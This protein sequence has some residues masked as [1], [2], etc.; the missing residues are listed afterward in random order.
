MENKS[1][2]LLIIGAGPGGQAAALEAAGLGLRVVMAEGRELGGVCLN[3][4]CIPTKTLLHTAA[5]LKE[6]QEARTYGLSLKEAQ[7]DIP[8]LFQRKD[9]VLAQL[10]QGLAAQLKKAGVELM[11]G[12]ATVLG[13]GLARLIS[14]EQGQELTLRA[15]NILIATGSRPSLPPIPG[16][17]LPGV[18]DSDGILAA[19]QNYQSLTIIG[20]GVI[21]LEM[22]AVYA[23]LGCR[24]TVL[25]AL[26]RV[27]ANFDQEISQHMAVQLKK[28][29]IKTY[30]GARLSRVRQAP[31]G[32]ECCFEHKGKELA[33]SSQAVLVATGRC[34]NSR[35]LF[36]PELDFQLERG[37]I[38]VDG[39]FATALPGVYAIGDVAL[40]S[41]QLA[42]VAAAQGVNAVRL[43]QGLDPQYD[44]SVLPA[45]VYTSPEIASVG[46]TPD[47]ARQ[48]GLELLTGRASSLANGRN[49]IENGG[50][51]FCRLV[52]DKGSRV[53]VGVQLMCPRASDI[54]CGLADGVTAGL[55]LNQLAAT[56]RPHPSFG[57]LVGEAV[58]DALACALD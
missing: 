47:Q 35:G 15:K 55:T 32:L 30:T 21:G 40:G 8:A 24:V 43:M 14:A 25:E 3:R 17:D 22:A 52:F 10:R 28:D 4:G 18:L 31:D 54:I 5:L 7:A 11:Y 51:G 23:A 29:G 38:P 49:L 27:L 1:C 34:A 37:Y 20:G 13:P 42:H 46:L 39:G 16:L 57:E 36:A 26:E 44:L 58:R 50:R 41:L 48:Q 33:V 9:A 53:L 2:D 12:Q 45:C 6:C 56:V 19:A